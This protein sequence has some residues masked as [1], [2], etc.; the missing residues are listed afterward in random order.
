MWWF[1]SSEY[2]WE[3][4]PIFAGSVAKGVQTI[5][6]RLNRGNTK[7]VLNTQIVGRIS[8]YQQHV[9]ITGGQT[10]KRLIYKSWR[11]MYSTIVLARRIDVIWKFFIDFGRVLDL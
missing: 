9:N 8:F 7:R 3:H 4:I 10:V 1:N 2:L 6:G 5:F 11:I